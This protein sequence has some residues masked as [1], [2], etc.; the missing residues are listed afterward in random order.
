MSLSLIGMAMSNHVKKIAKYAFIF[1][2][3]DLV[4]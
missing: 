3:N 1:A 4:V 2:G